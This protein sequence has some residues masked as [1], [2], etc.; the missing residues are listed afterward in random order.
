MAAFVNILSMIAVI[1]YCLKKF[2]WHVLVMLRKIFLMLYH[3]A[4]IYSVSWSDILITLINCCRSTVF[5]IFE[6]SSDM[7]KTVTTTAA[8][9]SCPRKC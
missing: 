5:I 3:V 6:S 4:I 2:S 8:S 9:V 1:A 7:I